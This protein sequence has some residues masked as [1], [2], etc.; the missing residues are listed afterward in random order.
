M[1]GAYISDHVARYESAKGAKIQQVVPDATDTFHVRHGDVALV[2]HIKAYQVQ[3]TVG[4]SFDGASDAHDLVV[5]PVLLSP[6]RSTQGSW[7]QKIKV[8]GEHFAGTKRPMDSASSSSA[9]AAAL[10]KSDT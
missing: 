10:P 4:K 7:H 9:C 6:V 1:N 5:V 8:A 3:S 2:Q